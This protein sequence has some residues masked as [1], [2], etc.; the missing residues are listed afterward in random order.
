[1]LVQPYRDTVLVE[2][3]IA[4]QNNY[5]LALFIIVKTDGATLLVG[6]DTF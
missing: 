2:V 4:L 5:L 3:M 6:N 1:M